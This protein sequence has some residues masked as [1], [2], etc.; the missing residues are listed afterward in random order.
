MTDWTNF[1]ATARFQRILK[2]MGVFEALREAGVQPG[3]TVLV[4]ERELEW[5]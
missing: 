2:A 5:Q 4:G 3:D 1:E